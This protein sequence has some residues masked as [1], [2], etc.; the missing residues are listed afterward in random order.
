M[1]PVSFSSALTGLLTLIVLGFALRKMMGWLLQIPAQVRLARENNAML[2]SLHAHHGIP[3]P[4]GVA[5]IK[6]PVFEGARA[7]LRA[8]LASR[9]VEQA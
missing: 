7:A 9:K 4:E 8:H 3:L 6:P 2:R 1:P 5:P